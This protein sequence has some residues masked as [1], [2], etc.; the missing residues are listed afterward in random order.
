MLEVAPCADD[1]WDR[2][3]SAQARATVFHTR[4]WLELIVA[5]SGAEL[6]LCR[7]EAGGR[8][9]GAAALF[10]FRRGPF[11]LAASPP[12]QAAVPYLGPLVDDALATQAL[13]ALCD[14]ARRQ[15]AVYFETRLAFEPPQADLVAAGF[16]VEARAT[17][18]LDL[19]PGPEVLWERSL[20]SACRR[21]V[22]K[23]ESSGVIVEEADLEEILP[24]YYAMAE[25]VFAK[26]DRPP[27]L[28]LDDYRRIAAAQ[29]RG[30]PVKVFA[31][32]LEG[33]VVAA[34]IFPH[35]SGAVYYLDGVS[36]PSGQAARPNN[37]LHWHVIQ[38]ACGAGVRQYDMVGAGI[39]GVAR[40]KE[41]F[42]PALVP[43]TYA[44]RNLSQLAGVARAAYARLAPAARSLQYGLGRLLRATRS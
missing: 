44:F 22:R 28:S 30:G 11:R 20:T 2:I 36:D 15:G 39:A 17:F 23:A 19:A 29:R 26:W 18:V 37:L 16:A 12:P 42:G 35:G 27:P 21:A 14:E 43:Y 8:V 33:V 7:F 32:R 10:L 34:G 25:S 24:R 5:V 31:A 38:W 1:E 13:A 9:A 41:S 3:A 4:E 40:F 6:R